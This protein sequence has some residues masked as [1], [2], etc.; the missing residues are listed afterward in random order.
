M[1]LNWNKYET[2]IQLKTN[3]VYKV[4]DRKM[5]TEIQFSPYGQAVVS[6]F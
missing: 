3:V 4:K 6:D 1:K 2:Q 5:S